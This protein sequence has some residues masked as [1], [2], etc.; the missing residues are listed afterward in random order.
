M[1]RTEAAATSTCTD[2]NL[3]ALKVVDCQLGSGCRAATNAGYSYDGN[4]GSRH[5][6]EAARDHVVNGRVMV[7]AS[8]CSEAAPTSY[9]VG[10]SAPVKSSD[11]AVSAAR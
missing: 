3:Q 8:G 7:R 9:Y 5:N 4:G 6:A 2:G 10:S 11:G 1:T